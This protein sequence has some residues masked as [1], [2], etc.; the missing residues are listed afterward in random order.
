MKIP[1]VYYDRFN[2]RKYT[3]LIHTMPFYFSAVTR[4][5]HRILR[6][7]LMEE[8]TCMLAVV[9]ATGLVASVSYA[10]LED[11]LVKKGEKGMQVSPRRGSMVRTLEVFFAGIFACLAITGVVT[12]DSYFTVNEP[13]EKADLFF[14]KLDL[15]RP[16]LREISALLDGGKLEDALN[17]WRDQVV[18]RLREHDF[19]EFGWHGYAPHPRPCGAVDALTGIVSRET[20]LSD[21]DAT[22]FLDIYGM[23][24]LPHTVEKINWFV[25]IN[26][27]VDWGHPKLA[28]LDISQKML[29][30]DYA[31]FEFFKSFT[32]RY[33]QTGDERYREKAFEIMSDFARN[34]KREFWR[35]Y[36]EKGIDDKDI[37]E[38]YRCDW[39]LHTNG[40]S[41]GWRL[42]NFLKN[43][44]GLCKCLSSDKSEDWD[45]VLKPVHGKLTR[46]ELDRIPAEQLADIA[47]S[48]VEDHTGKLLWFCIRPGAVPNQRAEGLKALAFLSVIFPNFKVT[49]QLVEYVERAY[50]EMLG[51]NILPDGGSLEQSFNYNGQD[52]EGLEELIRFFGDRPPRYAQTALEKVKARRAVDDGLQTPLGGLPQVGNSHDVL[53][54]N[55]WESE[56][57]A[58]RYQESE[59]IRG[60]TPVKPQLYTSKAFPYSGFFAMRS[61]WEMKDLY[62]FFMAGRPQRGHSMRDNNAIQMT[63][64]GRQL[65]VCGG[66]P[67]YGN[68]RTEDVRGADF[69]LSEASSLKNNTVIVDGHSQS[70]NAPR[71]EK[72][73]KTPIKSRWHSSERYDLVDGL[74]NLGYGEFENGRDVNV[75]MSVEHY[76]RVIFIKQAKF[77]LIE[78]RMINKGE[79]EHQYTQVWNFLPYHEDKDWRNSIAGFEGKQFAPGNQRFQTAVPAGPYVDFM[80]FGPAKISYEKYFGH[81]DPWLGWYA[82]G[83]GDAR[84]AMDVHVN[85]QSEDS[86]T[87]LTL[88][89]PVDTRRGPLVGTI[90]RPTGV[91]ET[92]SGLDAL[93]LTGTR[94]I[95]LS[96]PHQEKLE[97]DSIS[98]VARSLMVLDD[99]KGGVSGIAIGCQELVINGKPV[100]VE[101]EDFE[102]VLNPKSSEVETTPFFIPEVPIISE[103]KPFINVSNTPPVTITGATDGLETRYTLDGTEPTAESPVYEEPIKLDEECI[104]QARFFKGEYPLQFVARQPYKAWPWPPREP[105]MTS[106][107]SLELGLRYDYFEHQNSIRLFDLMQQ[108]PAKSGLCQ[109]YSLDPYKDDTKFG[110]KF[111]GYLRI[112]ET[113]MYRFYSDSP[114][115]ARLFIYNEE[116]DL[117][118]PAVVFSNYRDPQGE[119]SAALGVGYH[120]LEIHYIKAWGKPNQLDIEIEGPGMTRQPIPETW[121]FREKGE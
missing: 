20:Y 84:P 108:K 11:R 76:R 42:K 110:L 26:G 62:L 94:L 92:V 80:H 78:D 39:R 19:N 93:I 31:N 29:K 45:D 38:I 97:H 111:R 82:T 17:L 52:K 12:G 61:G 41:M 81:R 72:A 15:A 22:G 56:E 36:H 77:W 120:K 49:P 4:D 106:D 13:E 32:A 102:F 55:V 24:G 27:D 119:D 118:V 79:D 121:L 101:A 16:E 53:G 63:A 33:W 71:A 98:A 68:F 18:M 23:S 87:L 107:G 10:D 35:D 28:Q 96:S 114:T 90:H 88:M 75:D 60:K 8:L 103:P 34:H 83:I 109:S 64:Y 115:G 67:T 117:Q 25:D 113:G 40:L 57:A 66:S 1:F 21:P 95:Y 104:V 47:V 112:P 46:E 6:R 116:C 43:M 69:Y 2:K 70:K 89:M 99:F 100:L 9:L 30:I 86:D 85:W 51:S 58:R 65:V 48:L 54:K 5:L 105:D 44:A 73:Y 50:E 14:Q 91:S 37:R 59:D 74:Y 7:S 3:K